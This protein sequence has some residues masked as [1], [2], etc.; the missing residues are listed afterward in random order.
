MSN[1]SILVMM[2]LPFWPIGVPM[3]VRCTG[4]QSLLWWICLFDVRDMAEVIAS[5][6]FQSL[7]WWICLFDK[8][9]IIKFFPFCSVSIL[10]MMD[11]P[12][13]HDKYLWFYWAHENLVSI[14]V[15]MDLPFWPYSSNNTRVKKN[16]RF[17]PCYDGFAF[18]TS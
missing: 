7:L 8:H 13:W 4:F 17:N 6:M 18:L 3:Y 16:K 11:L 15:M 9:K 10:V 1:V 14:L 12:F 2:D 5:F